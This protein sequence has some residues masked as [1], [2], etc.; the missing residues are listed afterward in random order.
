MLR[1]ISRFRV[2]RDLADLP[3]VFTELGYVRREGTTLAPWAGEGYSVLWTP[4]GEPEV[5]FW[6]EQ[7]ESRAERA[8][9]V[10][11]L[12]AA[13]AAYA[14]PFLEGILYWKLTTKDYHRDVEPFALMLGEG[15]PLEK[16]LG[17]F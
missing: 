17:R 4:G 14:E 12:H 1:E 16:A 11:A 8:A 13:H 10:A 5:V 9:A 7:P 3:V 2:S 6:G 15:D